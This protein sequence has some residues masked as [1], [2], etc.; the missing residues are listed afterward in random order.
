MTMVAIAYL[1]CAGTS[2]ASAVL[3]LRAYF[4][5]AGGRLLLWCGIFF[6][7]MALENVLLFGDRVAFPDW[8]LSLAHSTIVLTGMVL[9]IYGLIWETE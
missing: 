5:R 2:F 3:L 1:L 8:D 7:A 9:F 6:L 4:K